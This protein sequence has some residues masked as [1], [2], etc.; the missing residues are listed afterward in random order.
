M[1]AGKK[2]LLHQEWIPCRLS[3]HNCRQ[4]YSIFNG[5]KKSRCNI[6]EDILL[7]EI[8]KFDF[9]H[10]GDVKEPFGMCCHVTLLSACKYEDNRDSGSNDVDEELSRLLIGGMNII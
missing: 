5:L 8:G 9:M 6:F 10:I 2:Y 3:V 4:W 7:L 1:V